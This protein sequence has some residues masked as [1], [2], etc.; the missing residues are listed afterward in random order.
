MKKLDYYNQKC[1]YHGL[2]MSN[3]SGKFQF[4]AVAAVRPL[5]FSVLGGDTLIFFTFKTS[6]PLSPCLRLK[7]RKKR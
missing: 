5:Y 2:K 7:L 3:F 6:T 4:S 1:V